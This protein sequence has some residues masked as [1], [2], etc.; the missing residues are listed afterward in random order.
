MGYL[1]SSFQFFIMLVLSLGIWRSLA[2]EMHMQSTTTTSTI[3]TRAKAWINAHVEYSQKSTYLGYRQDCSGFVSYAWGLP[4]TNGGLTT[5]NLASVATL[6][7]E[8]D[9]VPGDILLIAGAACASVGHVLIFNGWTTKGSHAYYNALENSPLQGLTGGGAHVDANPYCSLPVGQVNP[10]ASSCWWTNGWGA[11]KYPYYSCCIPTLPCKYEPYRLKGVTVNT[12]AYAD[13]VLNPTSSSMS[14]DTITIVTV[15]VALFFALAVIAA[16]VACFGCRSPFSKQK[17]LILSTDIE[18]PMAQTSISQ[19]LASV[20]TLP[21]TTIAMPDRQVSD[22][23]N[24]ESGSWEMGQLFYSKHQSI[25][26]SR[27]NDI[28][29]TR[30]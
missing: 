17:T 21:T 6:I 1:L 29:A 18:L 2:E 9:L 10:P 26:V 16:Y 7:N 15:S 24:D 12:N 28:H 19:P 22:G 3:I 4:N 25:V 27:S 8:N 5:A 13:D 11:V 20:T 23:E 14:S 30:L